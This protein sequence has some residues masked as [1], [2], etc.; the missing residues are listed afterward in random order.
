MS[1]LINYTL[2]LN[3]EQPGK[4]E[5]VKVHVLT[6]GVGWLRGQS[7]FMK[8]NPILPVFLPLCMSPLNNQL[9][10]DKVKVYF[11]LPLFYDG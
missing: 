4:E 11:S 1:S 7:Y 3:Q 9:T 5:P 6:F 8:P 2:V 10:S